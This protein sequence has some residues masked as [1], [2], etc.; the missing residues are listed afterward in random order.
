MSENGGG[1][2]LTSISG[3]HTDVSTPPHTHVPRHMQIEVCTHD[4]TAQPLKTGKRTKR[5]RNGEVGYIS[6]E[7]HEFMETL[8]IMSETW[9]CFSCPRKMNYRLVIHVLDY[10]MVLVNVGL[11]EIS[12][13]K[14]APYWI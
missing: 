4:C 14:R 1:R 6:T 5:K 9:K 2:L 3:L 13:S 7:R 10:W 8:P 11:N 12:Q